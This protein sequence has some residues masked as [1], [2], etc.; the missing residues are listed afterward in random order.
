MGAPA[1]DITAVVVDPKTQGTLYVGTFY[2]GVLEEPRPREDVDESWTSRYIAMWPAP[3][4]VGTDVQGRWR[5]NS[6]PPSVL[7]HHRPGVRLRRHHVPEHRRRLVLAPSRPDQR[8]DRGRLQRTCDRSGASPRGSSPAPG[9]RASTMSIKSWGVFVSRDSGRRW[10]RVVAGLRHRKVKP[11]IN[12]LAVA[13][14]TGDAYATTNVGVFRLQRGGQHWDPPRRRAAGARRPARS[15][16]NPRTRASSRDR[17]LRGVYVLRR[18][19]PGSGGGPRSPGRPSRRSRSA[20]TA[21]A[22]SPLLPD[23]SSA[24]PGGRDA[25]S[26]PL[27]I[28]TA[29]TV[30]T[31]TTISRAGPR[32]AWHEPRTPEGRHIPTH[33][34]A[35]RRRHRVRRHDGPGSSR[36]PDGLTWRRGSSFQGLKAGRRGRPRW[37]A[38][39]GTTAYALV[40]SLLGAVQERGRGHLAHVASGPRWL[41]RRGD[42]LR[43]PRVPTSPRWCTPG[44]NVV[45]RQGVP[46]QRTAARRGHQRRTAS[47]RVSNPGR[48]GRRPER[49]ADAIC[50]GTI[51]GEYNGTTGEEQNGSIYKTKDGGASLE[52]DEHRPPARDLGVAFAERSIR[53]DPR[54]LYAGTEWSRRVQEQRRRLPVRRAQGRAP[55]A[56]GAGGHDSGTA[57]PST[58]TTPQAGLRGPRAKGPR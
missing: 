45:R 16:I 5:W 26:N 39:T 4:V 11:G 58:R 12:A 36:A 27:I 23:T 50:V 15:A 10:Q 22:C 31:I 18:S 40:I 3:V 41:A 57:S 2:D 43:W 30:L 42:R 44:V 54:T 20:P 56:R 25:T 37:F 33:A 55:G 35:R 17:N 19:A 7:L 14:R 52:V 38:P 21:H 1:P 53:P 24:G 51:N 32:T 28:T 8:L 29:I 13:P 9:G 47:R 48:A 46:K 34:G 6:A 49:P